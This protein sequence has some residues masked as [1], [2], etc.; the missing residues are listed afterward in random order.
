MTADRRQAR[1]QGR[2]IVILGTY[3]GGCGGVAAVLAGYAKAG[4]GAGKRV[5]YLATHVSGS[6]S[7]KAWQFARALVNFG[8]AL[9]RRDVALVHA[10]AASRSSF[11][12]K[13]VF[14][15]LARLFR[16]PVLLH[17]HGGEFERFYADESS[18]LAKRYIRWIMRGCDRVV[19][20]SNSWHRFMVR[21]VDAQRLITISN[22]V[23]M[24][25]SPNSPPDAAGHV[26][27]FM[28]R[29]SPAKGFT[30]L[31]HAV[32]DLNGAGYQVDLWAAGDG[33]L[34]AAAKQAEGLGIASRVRLLGWLGPGQKQDALARATVFC[35]PSYAEGLPMALLEAMAAGRAVVATPVGGIPE[36][37]IHEETGLL[38]AAGDRDG[39]QNALNRLLRDPALR[40][41]LGAAA[42]AHI[43]S[44]FDVNN[45]V[46]AVEAL[47]TELGA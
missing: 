9:L 18:P 22:G 13:S 35:L 17:L 47:Y 45:S 25:L 46:K 14:L 11:Y 21:L 6:R 33:D 24:P 41:R 19:V 30:D 4:L 29:L 16:I 39:L 27:L 28:G 38:V 1:L 20:L 3:S 42:Q 15:L 32:T 23:D 43:R 26:I 44:Q 8:H 40:Q 7:R 31:L 2:R 37:V 34:A 36:V 12:R 5:Q 10:H